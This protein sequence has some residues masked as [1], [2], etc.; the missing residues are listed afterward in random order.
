ME[1]SQRSVQKQNINDLNL[2]L[3]WS[4]SREN[5]IYH[6][7]SVIIF[8]LVFIKYYSLCWSGKDWKRL[9]HKSG[10]PWRSK[11]WI[12]FDWTACPVLNVQIAMCNPIESIE[13]TRSWRW[14]LRHRNPKRRNWL[15]RR[16]WRSTP[17]PS[18]TRYA[19]IASSTPF[20]RRMRKAFLR[21]VWM[22]VIKNGKEN[23]WIQ[24]NLINWA[25]CF[26]LSSLSTDKNNNWSSLES[27]VSIA[28]RVE[29]D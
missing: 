14:Q 13:L 10:P 23:K 18:S 11:R 12:G 15:I 9:Q 29:T 4:I 16:R 21:F 2:K 7:L 27:F 5:N 22:A 24:A 1:D 28:T 25:V 8:N 19:R 17:S 6:R 26:R 20:W 3:R